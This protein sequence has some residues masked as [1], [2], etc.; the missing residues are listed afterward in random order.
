MRI[1]TAY[2]KA[3][4]AVDRIESRGVKVTRKQSN[5]PSDERYMTDDRLDPDQYL[6][7]SFHPEEERHWN[8]IFHE[9]ELLNKKVG[10][11]VFRLL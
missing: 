1:Q 8:W 11:D 5:P 3:I 9:Q 10:L 7:V 2:K 4:A 6:H